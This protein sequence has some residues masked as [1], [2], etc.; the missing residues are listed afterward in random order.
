MKEISNEGIKQIELRLLIEFDRLCREQGFRYSICGGTLIGAIRHKGF[1]PW[2]DD[3]DVLM[4]RKDFEAFIKYSH[5]NAVPFELLHYTNNPNYFDGIAKIYD[6]ST[7]IDDGF[8]NLYELKLGVYVDV[9]PIDGAG[10]DYESALKLYNKTKLQRRMLGAKQWKKYEFSKTHSFIYE[11][12]RMA[13]FVAS[14]AIKAEH[15]LEKIDSVYSQIPI[16]ESKYAVSIYGSYGEKEIIPSYFVESYISLP[17]EGVE[18][19]AVERYDEFLTKMYGDYM[20]LPPEEKR[21]SRHG[22]KAYYI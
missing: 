15:M 1:I 16:E 13:A 7:I 20:Q 12:L 6:K 8:S 17:F 3:I 21:V 11:P 14:R 2:D 22:F 10:K 9:F 5:D 4:P 18:V 19:M